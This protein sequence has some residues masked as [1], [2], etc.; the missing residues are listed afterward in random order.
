MHHSFPASSLQSA[1]TKGSGNRLF[2]CNLQ[3]LTNHPRSMHIDIV[4]LDCRLLNI[5]KSKHSPPP[6]QLKRGRSGQPL[7]VPSL[8]PAPPHEGLMKDRVLGDVRLLVEHLLL[9]PRDQHRCSS[10]AFL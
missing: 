9:Q 1:D 2:L 5:H 3:S 7:A 10:M 6:S 8:L 4:D